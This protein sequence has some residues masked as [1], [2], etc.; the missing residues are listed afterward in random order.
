MRFWRKNKLT[1]ILSTAVIIMIL[2]PIMA[3]C[4][5]SSGS[6]LGCGSGTASFG[7]SGA[8]IADSHI[9]VGSLDGK[10]VGL[11]EATGNRLFNPLP[12]ETGTTGGFLGC[13]AS[14][15]IIAIY[16]TPV[17]YG[18][19]VFVAG[20]NGRIYSIGANDGA[21]IR[22]FDPERGLQPIVGGL[23][24]DGN[25]LYFGTTSGYVYSVNLTNATKGSQ[26]WEFKTEEKIWA[27]PLVSNGTVYIGSF[28]KI[29]YAIDAA[30]GTNKWQF[31][32]G[33][34]I[35]NTPVLQDGVLYFGT[36]NRDFYAVNATNGTLKWEADVTA[37]NWY[38]ANPIMVNNTIF[39]PN[40]DGKVYVFNA[41]NGQNVIEP[42]NIDS[43]I[44]SSPILVGSDIILAAED[45]KVWSI[46]T[47]NN[48]ANILIDLGQNIQISSKIKIAAPLSFSGNII[49]IHGQDNKLYTVNAD[50]GVLL[51][52]ESLA[53]S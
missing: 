16:G 14:P 20:N 25:S 13:G 34:P 47:T 24:I 44:S 12:L 52:S 36:L 51:W 18:E 28:D 41:E 30:T 17:V 23:T 5:G 49:Y 1:V 19:K 8:T 26:N 31:K 45:G 40:L 7:W 42:I 6:A 53:S 4:Y 22:Y 29:F 46:N 48:T 21:L 9:Y 50:T 37:G 2:A 38:F 32:A 27:T 15:V 39:A 3:G 11:E 43:P 35:I 33:G 10:L